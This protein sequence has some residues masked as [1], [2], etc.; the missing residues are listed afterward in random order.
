MSWS[1][2]AEIEVSQEWQ[3]T[4]QI[5]GN[6][7]YIRVNF[8]TGVDAVLSIAQIDLDAPDVIWDERR[9]AGTAYGRILEFRPSPIL[10]RRAIA[11]R[12]AAIPPQM[13]V[14]IELSSTPLPSQGTGNG[15]GGNGESV[16]DAEI[17]ANV[18][19]LVSG[20]GQI[21]TILNGSLT[22][23]IQSL[24]QTG[25]EGT[26]ETLDSILGILN[27]MGSSGLTESQAQTLNNILTT[28]ES[29]TALLSQ[30]VSA[31][32]AL[33]PATFTQI[34]TPYSVSQSSV[35]GALAGTFSNL[36][37]SNPAT[38]AATNGSQA[39]WIRFNFPSSTLVK[40]VALSGGN[41]PDWGGVSGYLNN[42]IFQFS[43]DGN[44]WINAFTV[45]GISDTGS[46]QTQYFLLPRPLSAPFW[47]L[48]GNGFLSVTGVS[49]LQ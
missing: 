34:S 16:L 46:D 30:A 27:Q 11:V 43:P 2:L 33:V 22:E 25:F 26:S 48:S 3:F 12:V 42:R 24:I 10:N 19:T 41:L 4:P 45:T 28:A 1:Q 40:A 37:D 23:N 49:F 39:E 36:T 35:Y 6:L 21:L 8:L 7:G 9:I 38:G 47:R 13:R 18:A 29:N 20:Q 14:K 44:I 5:T 32:N 31:L 17:L 15:G